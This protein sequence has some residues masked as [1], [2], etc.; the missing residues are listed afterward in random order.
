VVVDTQLEN[1][2]HISMNGGT[3]IQPQKFRNRLAHGTKR[4]ANRATAANVQVF[5]SP[6]DQERIVISC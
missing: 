1:S 6:R 3:A 4:T 5:F 2:F